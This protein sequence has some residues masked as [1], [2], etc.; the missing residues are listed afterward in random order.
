MKL[1]IGI[2]FATRMDSI[3]NQAST[4][5]PRQ[6]RHCS[7]GI[8]PHRRHSRQWFSEIHLSF[9]SDGTLP[10]TRRDDGGEEGTGMTRGG[11]MSA[12]HWRRGRQ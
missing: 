2:I 5:R 1:L 7:S 8:H 3:V 12:G 11:W 4:S 10:Q 6:S 9:F